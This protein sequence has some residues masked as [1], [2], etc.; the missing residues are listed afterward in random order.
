MNAEAQPVVGLAA[1]TPALQRLDALLGRLLAATEARGGVAAAALR[2]LYVSAEEAARLLTR[3]PGAA[4][5]AVPTQADAPLAPF[6]LLERRYGLSSFDTDLLLIALAPDIDLRY[7]RLYG[8]FQDDATRR[9]AT[10]DLALSLRT[11]TPSEKL[12]RLVHLAPDAPLVRQGLVHLVPDPNHVQP[13]LL[14]HY[15]IVDPQIV[16]TLLS[17]PGPDGRLARFTRRVEATHDLHVLELPPGVAEALRR[18]AAEAR[19]DGTALALYFHGP[20][21]A[22]QFAAARALAGELRQSVLAADLARIGEDRT[23]LPV[24]FREARLTDA[25]LYL[26]GVDVLGAERRDAFLALLAT[27]R[28]ERAVVVLTGR[29][30]WAPSDEDPSVIAVAFAAPDLPTRCALWRHRLADRGIALL[31]NEVSALAGRFRLTSGQ[32]GRAAEDA[33]GRARWRGSPPVADDLFAGARAQS[34]RALEAL[35]RK[36]APRRTLDDLVLPPDQT[37][38]LRELCEQAQFR[39]LV[40]DEWGFERKLSGGKGLNALFTGPPGTGKTITAEVIAG[41]LRLDLFRIDL[42]QVVSKYIGETEKNLDRI[43][44]AAENAGAVLFFDE[45]DAL[46]GKR[47]EVRDAHDRYA[48]LEIAYLLQKMEEHEG[49]AILATNLRQNL[50]DA[51][52]RRLQ[53]VV[54]FPFPDEEQRR[55]IWHVTFPREAPL[56]PD[57]DTA[58]LARDVKLAGGNIRNI[59]MAAAFR[60]AAVGEAI[61]MTHLLA[62]ARREYQKLGRT[63]EGA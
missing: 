45:A 57:V 34:G 21:G 36:I 41:A 54:E 59:A 58:L 4:A 16:R 27:L 46:F 52:L 53:F 24:L 1:L 13:P 30:R 12:A 61:T 56:A 43:F 2:G 29:G 5:F 47:S 33:I 14:A 8:F 18:V 19:T 10:V 7:E 55:R 20:D 11:A 60:A 6:A 32:I 51:F 25:L 31:E 28:D 22:G 17:Q 15:L 9:R 40:L 50:D 38:Q 3:V 63:W 48:N 39:A 42:A 49:V 44:R 62:A 37:A 35:A 23:M 26:R